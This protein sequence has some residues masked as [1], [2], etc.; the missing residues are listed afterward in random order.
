MENTPRLL[1][2]PCYLKELT[3]KADLN[4]VTILREGR[5]RK[6]YTGSKQ[7]AVDI[8]GRLRESGELAGEISRE[9]ERKK[10]VAPS[11]ATK[12]KAEEMRNDKDTQKAGPGLGSVEK[13]YRINKPE[14]RARINTM[15]ASQPPDRRELYFWTVTFPMQTEDEVIYR[16]YNTWLTRLRKEKILRNYLWVCERQK[17]GTLHFHIAITHKMPVKKANA[18]MG[19]ALVTCAKKG[20]IAYSVYLCKRYNGVHISK[21]KAGKQALNFANGKRGRRALI[22]YLSKYITKNDGSFSHL[23]WHNSR[24]FSQLFTGVTF[25]LE[26]FCETFALSKF[27]RRHSAIKNLYFQFHPW[28]NGPPPSLEAE[29]LKLNSYI[30]N[31]N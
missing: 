14:I 17:N 8:N 20:E 29:L 25:T 22:G 31:L 1:S 30:Q 26:E 15:I 18:Y 27:V 28:I 6:R 7:F 4:G 9:N 11:R 2:V 13:S 12:K 3:I 10:I 16:I 21:D 5:Y 19:S 24:G 23:A